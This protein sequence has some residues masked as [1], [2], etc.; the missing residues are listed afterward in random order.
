MP[1]RTKLSIG[2]SA[3]GKLFSVLITAVL[4][5]ISA[6]A[7]LV[8][9][10][11]VASPQRERISST[12]DKVAS[13]QLTSKLDT[14]GVVGAVIGGVVAVIFLWLAL[15]VFLRA[16][17]RGAW[18]EG[19]VLHMRG[20]M[21]H[22]AANLAA[23]RVALHGQTLTAE[24]LAIPLTLPQEEL[25]MLANA[26]SNTRSGSDAGIAVAERLRA[27]TRDPFS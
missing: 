7:A 22:K 13:E 2:A 24:G 6:A 11:F 4:A 18:L 5:V 10:G 14:V 17:R 1:P 12:V 3:A 15:Y 9:Y 27:M 23:G 16:F 19:S 25:L 26:I 8:G 20:A 21:R